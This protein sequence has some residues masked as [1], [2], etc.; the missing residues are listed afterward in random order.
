MPYFYTNFIQLVQ[1]GI[2][3]LDLIFGFTGLGVMKRLNLIVFIK[4]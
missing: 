4:D 2:E 1:L 3:S